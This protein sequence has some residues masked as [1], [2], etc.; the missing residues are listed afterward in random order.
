ME[1]KNV[2]MNGN[3]ENSE[4]ENLREDLP[5]E[6]RYISQEVTIKEV[7]QLIC[8][9]PYLKFKMEFYERSSIEISIMDNSDWHKIREIFSA[10]EIRSQVEMKEK[11]L[12]CHSGIDGIVWAIG[13]VEKNWIVVLYNKFLPNK[14][15]DMVKYYMTELPSD[16]E[17]KKYC[18]QQKNKSRE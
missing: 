3:T 12:I 6:Y 4:L 17:W 9:G 11:K 5:K 16:K 10:L 1:R 18:E 2:V 13:P 14:E 7:P 8:D 15:E